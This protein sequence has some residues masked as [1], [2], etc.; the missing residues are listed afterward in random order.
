MITIK[1]IYDEINRVAPFETQ[2]SF[3]NSGFLVGHAQQQVENVLVSLD[4]TPA[5]VEE[6][7]QMGVQL[8]VSHHPVIFSPVRAITDETG[9]GQLLISLI[10]A[11]IGAI[12]AHTNLD[13]AN[14]G[15]NDCLARALALTEC[16]V[17]QPEGE[18]CDIGVYGIGRIG[19]VK[20]QSVSQFADFVKRTLGANSVRIV[21]GGRTVSRVAVG[22]GACGD[23]IETAVLAGCDTFVTSDVR[24]HQFLQAKDLGL[25]LLDVGHFPSEHVVCATL[26][27]NLQK[28]FPNLSICVS[29]VHKEVYQAI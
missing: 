12:C 14:G 8:I 5:V 6:A 3:D 4:I 9:T 13:M 2:L 10:K 7:K 22:G 19:Q 24:Y 28:T 15:V 27:D 20:L 11:G 29:K 18:R 1:D 23:M 21:D 16:A 17:L 26:A 25:N